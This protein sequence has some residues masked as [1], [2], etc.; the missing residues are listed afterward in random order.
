MFVARFVARTRPSHAAA[1]VFRRSSSSSSGGGDAGPAIENRGRKGK[2]KEEKKTQI[3]PPTPSSSAVAAV[4]GPP[5]GSDGVTHD[6]LREELHLLDTVGMLAD[7][8]G[9]VCRCSSS[10]QH[11][12]GHCHA[13]GALCRIICANCHTAPPCYLSNPH[14][15]GSGTASLSLVEGHTICYN[16]RA[17][18][19]T[20][21]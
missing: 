20:L 10:P 5:N 9:C 14:G 21:L 12:F 2:R 17:L 19:Q 1:A 8:V 4:A 7:G 3:P 16:Y 6:E 15:S 13:D 18:Q 11:T